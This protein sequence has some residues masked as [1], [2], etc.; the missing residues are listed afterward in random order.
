LLVEGYSNALYLLIFFKY[1]VGSF[2]VSV[3]FWFPEL[4]GL[5]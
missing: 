5:I 3:Q 1:F 2:G 4:Q